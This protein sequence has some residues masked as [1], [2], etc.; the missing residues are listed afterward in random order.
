MPRKSVEE[1]RSLYLTALNTGNWNDVAVWATELLR[2]DPEQ[3]W[4]WGNRGVALQKLGHPLDA[5]IN[6]ERALQYEQSAIHYCNIGAACQDFDLYDA[7]IENFDKSVAIDPTIAA[8]HMNRGHIFKWQKKYD[9]AL[10]AY[11]ECIRV[12][13]DAVDGH[14]GLAFMLLMLGQYEEGWKEFEWRWKSEQLLPR[15]LA[16]P[17]W[18]GE[19]LNGKGILIYGEQGLGDIIQFSRYARVLSGRYPDAKIV[20]EGKYQVKRLLQTIPEV[21][22]VI[23]YG[24]PIPKVD[25]AIAMLTLAAKFTPTVESIPSIEREFFINPY[26][27]NVW[28][29]KFDDIPKE[30]S[31]KLKVG[32]CWAGMARMTNPTALKVDS[33]RSLTLAD[34]ADAAL[35]PDILWVSL[36]KGAPADQLKKPPNNMFIADYTEDMYDFYETCCAIEQ[37]DLVISVDTAVCHA[38][39]S[40]GK[41][42]WMISR[43]DGCWRW[44]HDREDTPWYPSMRIFTQDAAH[45][46]RGVLKKV[47]NEL[48]I[49]VKRRKT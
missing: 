26:D 30:H 44:L 25:Y 18:D 38:A 17:Q 37:C 34:F 39:A 10:E 15:G 19:D 13:P 14:L 3:P 36:Q 42:V 40:L 7:A 31:K 5:I 12:G 28:K 29:T 35:V 27:V 43:W 1:C 16:L 9:E 24:E 22:T 23:N 6:H 32:L 48:A 8:V 20:I 47:A 33:M 46:W 49:E 21:D 41:P 4:V 45:D 2:L 11:R